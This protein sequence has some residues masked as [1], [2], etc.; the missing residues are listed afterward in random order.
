MT[1]HHNVW[2][3]L[4][5]LECRYW[6]D[7]DSNTGREAHTFYSDDATFDIGTPDNRFEGRAAIKGFY[8]R[9]RAVGIRTTRHIVTNF[10]LIERGATSATSRSIMSLIGA[11]GAPPQPSRPAILIAES[12]NRYLRLNGG[13]LVQARIFQN[14]FIDADNLPLNRIGAAQAR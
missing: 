14:L 13:W 12:T 11:D 8:D 1:D 7:V 4:W 10:D 5:A 3:E 2:Q 9:R 6:H